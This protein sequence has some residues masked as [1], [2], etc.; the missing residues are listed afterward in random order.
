MAGHEEN[1]KKPIYKRWWFIAF[2]I[3]ISMQLVFSFE[4]N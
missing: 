4:T 2:T 3:I 1:E